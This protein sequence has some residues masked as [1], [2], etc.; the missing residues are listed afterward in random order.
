MSVD[1]FGRQLG[2][3][4]GTRG[5]PGFGFKL[6]IDDQYD[7]ENKR[8]CN[9]AESREPNDAANLSLVK[10]L[11][12]QE[13]TILLRI[14][15]KQREDLDDLQLKIQILQ[16]QVEK[17]LKNIEINVETNLDLAVRNSKSIA[18]LEAAWNNSNIRD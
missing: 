15:T 3:N 18:S 5:P 12:Q 14:T 11:I 4:E 7:V 2:R 10:H 16:D 8:L 9:V 1:V 6:T 17:R 13:I